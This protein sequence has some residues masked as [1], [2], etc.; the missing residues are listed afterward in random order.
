MFKGG[1]ICKNK[2]TSEGCSTV[3]QLLPV[4][5]RG[6]RRI[7]SPGLVD[8]VPMGH[9][10]FQ[11]ELRKHGKGV[12]MVTRAIASRRSGLSRWE[13]ACPRADEPAIRA[14]AGDRPGFSVSAP[15]DENIQGRFRPRI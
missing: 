9:L 6:R 8:F 4:Q 5:L 12:P 7:F 14:R 1:L 11:D 3:L 2:Q 13:V 15:G 10:G